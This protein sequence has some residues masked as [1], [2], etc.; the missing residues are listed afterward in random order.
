MGGAGPSA[1]E[2]TAQATDDFVNSLTRGRGSNPAI[3]FLLFPQ[4]F[5]DD[6][7][8]TDTILHSSNTDS[9][10]YKYYTVIQD[11]IELCKDHALATCHHPGT[12]LGKQRGLR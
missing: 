1:S 11:D 7:I 6:T 9:K 3:F 12:A 5:E 10:L 4:Y 8:Y 2:Q